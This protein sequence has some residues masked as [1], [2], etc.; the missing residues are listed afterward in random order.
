[1]FAPDD[2][3]LH[4][5]VGYR[6]AI[7]TASIVGLIADERLVTEM[8]IYDVGKVFSA[9]TTIAAFAA[10]LSPPFGG[11]VGGGA[12]CHQVAGDALHAVAG[13]DVLEQVGL[14]AEADADTVDVARRIEVSTRDLALLEA[15]AAE[16]HLEGAELVE[17][18]ALAGEQSLLDVF[19]RGGEHRNNI[20]FCNSRCKLNVLSEGLEIVVAGLH[21]AVAGVVDAFVTCGIGAGNNF[22]SNSH[23]GKNEK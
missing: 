18:D 14:G 13:A 7:R 3:L 4:P 23:S 6:V 9:S 22:V 10:P 15:L 21:G 2:F 11:G 19:L 12:S 20:G 8:G 1:M 5:G 16:I 17:H